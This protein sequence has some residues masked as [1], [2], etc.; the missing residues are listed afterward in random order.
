MMHSKKTIAIP[1]GATIREQLDNRYMKQ[2]EFAIRMDLSEK[3]ISRLINGRVEL[4][5]SVAIRL[6]SVLGLPA[7]FWNNLE[8]KYREKLARVIEEKNLEDDSELAKLFPYAKIS[9]LGWV[10]KTRR[11]EEKAINLRSFF[12]IAKLDL[13]ETLR[14][15]GIAYRKVGSNGEADYSLALW[16]QKAKIEA[17]NYNLDLININELEICIPI[18]RN[19]TLMKPEEF[20]EKLIKLLSKCGVALVFLPHIGGS[21]LHGASFYDGKHIVMG[22]TVRG[23]NADKFWFSLF[24]EL[25]HIISGHINNLEGTDDIDE[26]KADDFAKD[27][28]IPREDFNEFINSD[29]FTK[30]AII[31]FSDSID[32]ASG[33]VIGRLQKENF[34]PYNRYNELK[35]NYKIS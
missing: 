8:L 29:C 30:K 20:C 17:R 9:K 23:K 7:S 10:P 31:K 11:A 34:I 19:M 13:L 35:E 33:I 2:K 28:L 3:H 22:L 26:Q 18:I 6:E 12:E 24:H 4:T 5:K 16:A 25:Y 27:L 21:F 14:T 32:I 15:P 1:P